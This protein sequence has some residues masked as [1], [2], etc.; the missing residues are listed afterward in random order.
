MRVHTSILLPL[1]FAFSAVFAAPASAQQ[2]ELP[3]R[4]SGYYIA[5][6]LAAQFNKAWQE[7]GVD[8]S[9]GGLA[10][11]FRFGQMLTRHFG[12]GLRLNSGGGRS[13]DIDSSV[14]LVGLEG[15]W[16]F[17]TNLAL[18][19]GAGLGV[20]TV[21]D[22]ADPDAKLKGT[23][24]AGWSLALSWDWFVAGPNGNGGFAITPV[25]EARFVP[26]DEIN[27][28]SAIFGIEF[29]YWTGLQRDQLILPEDQAY[30]PR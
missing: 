26:G 25:V 27:A 4:R 12:L 1:L 18:R 21:K 15:Q 28:L 23:V 19:A 14:A 8:P 24:G 3:R 20:A 22:N 7:D 2:Q 30:K 11:G 17:A 10:F 13:G 16:E 6:V 29:S 9:A 5:P